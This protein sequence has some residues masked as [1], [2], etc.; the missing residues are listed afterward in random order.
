[1]MTAA[2]GIEDLLRLLSDGKLYDEAVAFINEL[3]TGKGGPIDKLKEHQVRGMENC[4]AHADGIRDMLAFANHQREKAERAE[5]A[6]LISYYQALRARLNGFQS[7]ARGEGL[8]PQGLPAKEARAQESYWDLRMAQEF[9]QH[10]G[11][12]YRL[13]K[14]T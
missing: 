11:A 1:M 2:P 3:D 12:E 4:A 13:R 14:E 7:R 5:N 6:D 8:A 10:A 9:I